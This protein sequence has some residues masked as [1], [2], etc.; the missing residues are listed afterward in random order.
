VALIIFDRHFYETELSGLPARMVPAPPWNRMQFIEP[1]LF[2]ALYPLRADPRIIM[3]WPC[4]CE[5][6]GIGSN[7]DNYRGFRKG[8]QSKLRA[9]SRL[10]C[11]Q[12]WI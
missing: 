12:I 8:I 3:R 10:L 6:V 9:A 1:M 5:T 4:N 2:D 7:G 11:P